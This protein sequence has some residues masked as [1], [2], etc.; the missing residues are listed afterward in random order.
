MHRFAADS[1]VPG[2]VVRLDDGGG[3][4]QDLAPSS[5]CLLDSALLVSGVRR[6]HV[7]G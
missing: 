2:P 7:H 3:T 5:C 6:R 1:S 4:L